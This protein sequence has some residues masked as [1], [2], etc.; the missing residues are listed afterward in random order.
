MHTVQISCGFFVYLQKVS[1][2]FLFTFN[3]NS[4]DEINYLVE[5]QSLALFVFKNACYF[6]SS[7]FLFICKCFVS[8]N[9]IET[10][11]GTKTKMEQ[12]KKETAS[13]NKNVKRSIL[14]FLVNEIWSIIQCLERE[15]FTFL[16]TI[17]FSFFLDKLQCSTEQ[18]C[19]KLFNRI[20]ALI[21]G[22]WYL[23]SIL[24]FEKDFPNEKLPKIWGG[25]R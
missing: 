8:I 7:Y 4:L 6:L 12:K 13:E 18:R 16:S 17:L 19:W 14:Q 2:S 11:H 21:K 22:F 9:R 23:N 20:T 10:L 5:F 15:E 24:C 1:N 25:N 3:F